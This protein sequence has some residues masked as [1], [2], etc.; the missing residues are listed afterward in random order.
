MQ[1]A[2]DGWLETDDRFVHLDDEKIENGRRVI[3]PT[4]HQIKTGKT[5]KTTMNMVMGESKT[6]S[7]GERRL[8]WTPQNGTLPAHVESS[9]GSRVVKQF[10]AVDN[11]PVPRQWGIRGSLDLII[12]PCGVASPQFA[13]K[14]VLVWD[15]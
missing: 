8:I 13:Y 6:V 9:D 11:A 7:D 15:R 14:S 1:G 4:Q 3:I 12:D 10:A 5:G 2:P